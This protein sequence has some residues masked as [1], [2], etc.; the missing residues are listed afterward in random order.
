ME[1]KPSSAVVQTISYRQMA[2]VSYDT[3]TECG[4]F[5]YDPGPTFFAW[6][7]YG[8]ATVSK[9]RVKRCK[10]TIPNNIAIDSRLF[11]PT[12]DQEDSGRRG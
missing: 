1:A 12:N 4:K 8:F 6:F 9:M 10:S 3:I 7:Y 11:A 5:D 2:C